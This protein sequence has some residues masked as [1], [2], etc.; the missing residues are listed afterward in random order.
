MNK[1]NDINE[2][3]C[4]LAKAQ[5]EIEDATK[6]KKGYGYKYADLSQLL[7]IVRPIFSKNGLCVSQMPEHG[8]CP[9]SINI[10]S[11]L[12]HSSGQ[13]IQSDYSMRVEPMKGNT[14]A[15]AA[16]SV[17]TYMRRYALAAI[18]GITQEDDDGRQGMQRENVIR[19]EEYPDERFNE[20]VEA[21]RKSVTLGENTVESIVNKI[22]KKF[23]LST[24]QLE[25]LM[26]LG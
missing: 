5:G 25:L 14:R 11:V 9:D 17:I 26:S 16:G 12:M 15:Q 23:I 4:A 13:W 2:L 24:D 21:W 8:A 7:Q 19:K 10:V 22:S 3:A 20:N 6:N 18:A 1:S